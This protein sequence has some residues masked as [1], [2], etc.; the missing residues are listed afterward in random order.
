M[1][2]ASA[3]T[4]S[5]RQA[6]VMK[7]GSQSTWQPAPRSSSATVSAEGPLGSTS[8]GFGA[9]PHPPFRLGLGAVPDDPRD[10]RR[11]RAV[12]LDLLD[13]LDTV[14]QHDD[15]GVLVAQ[16]GQPAGRVVVLGG[17]DRQHENVDRAGHLTGIGVHRTG[18]HDR[19][20][21]VGPQFDAVAG[22]VTAHQ[23]RMP[24]LVQ[25][26]GDRRAD[27]AGTD[28][29]DVRGDRTEITFL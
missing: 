2:P 5:L 15:D 11:R 23:H 18:H 21:A 22:S 26:R 7:S 14:L 28:E 10:H 29:C 24:G 20:F 17:F 27:G 4:S 3:L 8:R 9:Q 13:L 1:N 12:R 6:A 25:K 19:I 16:A